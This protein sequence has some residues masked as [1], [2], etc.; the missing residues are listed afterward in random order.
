MNVFLIV[1]ILVFIVIFSLIFMLV[2]IVILIILVILTVQRC[3]NSLFI[4]FLNG[5]KPGPGCSKA[6]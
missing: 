2:F 5:L 4:V 1:L 6:D 3:G